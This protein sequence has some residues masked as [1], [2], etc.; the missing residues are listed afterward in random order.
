MEKK[1]EKVSIAELKGEGFN[2][3]IPNKVFRVVTEGKARIVV[4]A[5]P[6]TGLILLTGRAFHVSAVTEVE[7]SLFQSMPSSK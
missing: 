1:W 5:N 6:A 7:N 3:D 2:L 4:P